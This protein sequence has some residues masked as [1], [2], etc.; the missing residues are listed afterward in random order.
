MLSNKDLVQKFIEYIDNLPDD[1]D[2]CFDDFYDSV[3][4]PKKYRSDFCSCALIKGYDK[5][6]MSPKEK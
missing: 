5:Y 6:K 3:K 2:A 1:S 4:V